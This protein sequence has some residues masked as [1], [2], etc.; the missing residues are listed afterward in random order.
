MPEEKRCQY[1]RPLGEESCI[2]PYFITWKDPETG[3]DKDYCIFHA[4]ME[5][6]KDNID[7]FWEMFETHFEKTIKEFQSTAEEEDRRAFLDCCGFVFPATNDRLIGRE[8]PYNV[9]LAYAIFEG[10]V[11]F[12]NADFLGA[13]NLYNAVFKD[14]VSFNFTKFYS[15]LVLDDAT[16]KK[17]T[18]FHTL[19]DGYVFMDNIEFEDEVNF[20]INTFKDIVTFSNTSF[21][22][23][24]EFRQVEFESETMFNSSKFYDKTEFS[25]VNFKNDTNLHFAEF[26]KSSKFSD[27]SFSGEADFA[28]SKVFKKLEFEGTE[29]AKK[30]NFRNL[31]TFFRDIEGKT[32][33][34]GHVLIRNVYF[35]RPDRVL[36]GGPETA[37]KRW[38]FAGS[39]VDKVV[40]VKETWPLKKP[41][42]YRFV[43]WLPPS[44]KPR[45]RKAVLD[46]MIAKKGEITWQEAEEVYRNLRL[47]YENRLAYETAGDFHYGQMECR[48]RDKK[49]RRWWDRWL[50]LLYRIFFSYGE[51]ISKPLI[52]LG[53]IIVTLVILLGPELAIRSLFSFGVPTDV[54]LPQLIISQVGRLAAVI[55][56]TFFVLA[57]RR[58]FKR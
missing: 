55:F 36:I 35:H 14:K 50:T 4:P 18:F 53:L 27:V 40:F 29:F 2:H 13:V 7:E 17:V 25:N 6:K 3:E 30:T 24:V 49:N 57:L 8:F 45:G 23:P 44:L 28:Y 10:E 26:H 9:Y 52:W 34:P 47:N 42:I 51:S 54:C 56:A 43:K 15:T 32:Y 33:G 19:F 12:G 21:N 16:F 41:F 39:R 46:E 58:R 37:L 1:E 5:A 22:K 11:S 48:R 31:R 38:S 20:Q